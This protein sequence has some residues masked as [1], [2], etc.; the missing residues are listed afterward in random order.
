MLWHESFHQIDKTVLD[1]ALIAISMHRGTTH[2][3][4]DTPSI[5]HNIK[6]SPERRAMWDT[7]R[8]QFA[9]EFEPYSDAACTKSYDPYALTDSDLTVYVKWAE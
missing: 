5:L 1:E 8:K 7:Y 9:Y 2:Q 6:E 3:I 4:D